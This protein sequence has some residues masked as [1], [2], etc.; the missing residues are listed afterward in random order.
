L[1]IDLVGT[2][3]VFMINAASFLAVI[4]ALSAMRVSELYPSPRVER[5]PGQIREGLRYVRERTDLL[6]PIA[7]VAIVGTFGFN[8]QVTLALM[9]KT[10]YLRGAG[11][12]GLLSSMLALGCLAGALIGARRHRRPAMRLLVVSCLTF[13]VL[14]MVC[15]LMPSYATLALALVPTGC[16]AIAFSTAANSSLQLGSDPHMRG[17]VMGLYMI[18]FA[19]GTPIGAPIVG[20]IAQ[21]FGARWSLLLGGALSSAVAVVVGLALVRAV[22]GREESPAGVAASAA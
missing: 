19:G 3:W 13:G 6:V 17:R 7:L 21:Q 1:L 10:V 8:F 16:A 15:G 22:R 11:G 2:G 14:E 9:D 18:V 4:A 12:Y 20:W 5:Q